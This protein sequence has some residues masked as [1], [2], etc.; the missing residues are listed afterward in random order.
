MN[1]SV[2]IQARMGSKRLPEKSMA[3][4]GK[5]RVIEWIFKRLKRCKKVDNI[6]LAT[7]KEE[8]DNVLCEVAKKNSIDFYR[9]SKDDVLKRYIDSSKFYKVENVVRVCADRPFIDPELIDLL[10]T[11]FSKLKYD[12]LYNHKSDNFNFWPVGFGA[13]IFKSKILDELYEKKL[14][15]RF[16]E[17]VTLYLY[18]DKKYKTKCINSSNGNRKLTEYGRFDLDTKSDLKKLDSFAKNILITDSF[19]KIIDKFKK[20]KKLN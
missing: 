19:I 5:F 13:E 17:H 15:E 9:G 16:K 12:L 4:L 14:N 1:T 8:N 6:I 7:T 11:D 18:K 10:V 2:I 20:L 3:K